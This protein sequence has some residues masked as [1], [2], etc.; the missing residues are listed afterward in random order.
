MM[1]RMRASRVKAAAMTCTIR[2]F[3]SPFRA[4]GGREKL[5]LPPPGGP[6]GGPCRASRRTICSGRSRLNLRLDDE[7]ELEVEAAW[8]SAASGLYPSW[9][10]EQVDP[11]MQYPNTPN[12][13]P[14]NSPRAIVFVIGTEIQERSSSTKAASRNTVAG[15]AAR[16]RRFI[17]HA[18]ISTWTIQRRKQRK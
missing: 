18:Q 3:E 10:D 16:V 9:T 1:L 12:V 8:K 17:L 4:D 15:V 13:T 7:E 2:I 6:G 5:L 14:L 11:S